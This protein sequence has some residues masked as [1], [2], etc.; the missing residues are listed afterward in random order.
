MM[1]IEE[2]DGDDSSLLDGLSTAEDPEDSAKDGG[3]AE[4]AAPALGGAESE[5]G[6]EEFWNALSGR[7]PVRVGADPLSILLQEVAA[8]ELKRQEL[9]QLPSPA[10]AP[11]AAAAH[12][13]KAGSPERRGRKKQPDGAPP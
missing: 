13:E 6:L 10:R 5:R 2:K 8:R 4:A 1:A 3:L 11:R 9:A 7:P 12:A